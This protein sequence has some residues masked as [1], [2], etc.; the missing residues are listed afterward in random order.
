MGAMDA[1]IA[2][3]EATEEHRTEVHRPDP[4]GDLLQTYVV[5]GQDVTDVDPGVLPADAAV[6]ADQAA[7]EVAEVVN[8]RRAG[9][10]RADG[11]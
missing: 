6:A 3:V 5:L 10:V 8:R 2:L 9:Y 11:R 7:L 4:V 1:P